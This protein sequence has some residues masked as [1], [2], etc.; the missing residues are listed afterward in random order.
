KVAELA[1]L[2]YRIRRRWTRFAPRHGMFDI[3]EN[4]H[5]RQDLAQRLSVFGMLADKRIRIDGFSG[6]QLAGE[7]IDQLVQNGIRARRLD[8]V[9]GC[10]VSWPPRSPPRRRLSL[11]KARR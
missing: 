9:S 6:L 2:L 1:K 8:G 5:D 4:L 7:F 11:S 3:R 10:H